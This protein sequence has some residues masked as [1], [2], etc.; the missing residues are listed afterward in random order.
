MRRYGAGQ[1]PVGAGGEGGQATV[2]FALVMPLILI[3]AVAVCQVAVF[4]NCRLILLAASR[5][6]ARRAAET[7]DAGEARAAALSAATALSGDRPRVSVTFPEGRSKGSP[8]KV[9]LTY[10]VPLVVPGLSRLIQPACFHCSTWMALEKG[11]R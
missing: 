11:S 3:L 7:G 5:E 8:V 6:G 1:P 4:L 9:E 10:R 2:E